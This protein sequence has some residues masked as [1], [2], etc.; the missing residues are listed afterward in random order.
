MLAHAER[1]GEGGSAH[2]GA[3]ALGGAGGDSEGQPGAAATHRP[4][5][6]HTAPRQRNGGLRDAQSLPGSHVDEGFLVQI[7]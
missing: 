5:V 7:V 3:T 1:C 6:Q 4:P 2:N